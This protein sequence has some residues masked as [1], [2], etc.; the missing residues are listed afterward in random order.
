MWVEK[1]QIIDI[2]FVVNF[3]TDLDYALW[4]WEDSG[5]YS[6]KSMY[7]FLNFGV[8]KGLCQNQFGF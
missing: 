6:V 8:S 1:N 2:L 5:L 7:N 4:Q 3:F